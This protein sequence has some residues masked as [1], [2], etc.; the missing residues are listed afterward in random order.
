VDRLARA[1]TQIRLLGVGKFSCDLAKEVP[2]LFKSFWFYRLAIGRFRWKGENSKS[3]DVDESSILKYDQVSV[4]TNY[5][6]WDFLS[7]YLSFES[8]IY[9]T[10][11]VEMGKVVP[12]PAGLSMREQQLSW[13]GAE[14]Q[15]SRAVARLGGTGT[16]N[17]RSRWFLAQSLYKNRDMI[18]RK[19]W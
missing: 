6:F 2:Q 4:K 8:W 15:L 19:K 18:F 12:V 17:D 3:A 9:L 11:K 10:S 7:K 13:V 5:A 1:G 16:K 14:Y